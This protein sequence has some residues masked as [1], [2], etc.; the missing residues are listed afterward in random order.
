MQN[1]Q[2]KKSTKELSTRNLD[3]NLIEF[4]K[5]NANRKFKSAAR[6]VIAMNKFKLR[7]CIDV[8]ETDEGE[9]ADALVLTSNPAAAP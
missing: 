8:T 5:F 6:A 1:P 2:L 4:R 7:N 3:A 9:S